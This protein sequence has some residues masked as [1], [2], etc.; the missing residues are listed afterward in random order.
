[1]A[2]QTGVGLL[3]VGLGLVWVLVCGFFMWW[4]SGA[5]SRDGVY[6]W[7]INAYRGAFI[8]IIGLFIAWPG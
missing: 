4:E 1:M 8:A 7:K 5:G 6:F 2:N 3:T